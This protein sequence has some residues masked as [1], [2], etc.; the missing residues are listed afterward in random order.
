[1]KFYKV[2]NG[3][4]GTTFYMLEKQKLTNYNDRICGKIILIE[5]LSNEDSYMTVGYES[6]FFD[7]HCYEVK[8]QEMIY[9]LKKLMVFE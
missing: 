2:T 5:S 7:E 4:F 9:K 6:E 1:M 8:D 3:G